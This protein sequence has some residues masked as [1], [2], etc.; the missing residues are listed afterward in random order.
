[1]RSLISS[2]CYESKLLETCLIHTSP[3]VDCQ[4]GN[5]CHAT[6]HPMPPPRRILQELVQTNA[7]GSAGRGM[8]A[9][10]PPSAHEKCPGLCTVSPPV[11]FPARLVSRR[12]SVVYRQV[13]EY[14]ITWTGRV[15][16][17]FAGH[18]CVQGTT[19]FV[20]S[21]SAGLLGGSQNYARL[22]MPPPRASERSLAR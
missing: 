11:L 13:P 8:T 3:E 12:S 7:R 1:M 9:A 10:R 6:T 19:C 17:F 15:A 14:F 5:R 18:V 20:V 2:R 22:V 21:V 4:P 16:A